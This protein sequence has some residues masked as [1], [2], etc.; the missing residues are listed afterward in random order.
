MKI[1]ALFFAFLVGCTLAH[2]FNAWKAKHSKISFDLKIKLNCLKISPKYNIVQ[3]KSPN[4]NY[5]IENI[6]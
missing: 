6:R 4:F 3:E 5:L 1:A 2:D